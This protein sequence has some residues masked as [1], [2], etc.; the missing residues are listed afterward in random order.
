MATVSFKGPENE[1]NKTYTEL[2]KWIDERGYRVSGP[3]IEIYSKK[4]EVVDGIT[5]LYSKIMMPV[6]EK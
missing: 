6:E 1:Y 4:P 5:I 2:V 3:P